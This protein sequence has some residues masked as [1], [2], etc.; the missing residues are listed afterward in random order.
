MSL[1]TN[2]DNIKNTAALGVSVYIPSGNVDGLYGPYTAPSDNDD[3]WYI[4]Y[5][6]GNGDTKR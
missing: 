6:D 1:I 3:D 2:I 5:V 4:E